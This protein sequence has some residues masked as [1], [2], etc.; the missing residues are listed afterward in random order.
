MT[1]VN[2][3]DGLSRQRLTRR[4]SGTKFGRISLEEVKYSLLFPPSHRGFSRTIDKRESLS[5]LPAESELVARLGRSRT[6]LSE[7]LLRLPRSQ[8]LV[9]RQLVRTISKYGRA[10]YRLCFSRS[11]AVQMKGKQRDPVTTLQRRLRMIISMI[12]SI[13][14]T[15]IVD[16]DVQ[17][18]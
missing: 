13:P 11:F 15:I 9:S 17:E 3:K 7:P 12:I 1:R 18:R 10:T 4:L 16:N 14:R 8:Q 5:N 2:K 6:T